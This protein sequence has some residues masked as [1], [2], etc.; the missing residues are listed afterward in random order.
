MYAFVSLLFRS[1][2]YVPGAIVLGK[3]L[4]EML[5]LKH[6][7]ILMVTHDIPE[8]AIK[9]LEKY[10]II[11][12]VEYLDFPNTLSKKIPPHRDLLDIYFSS[13]TSLHFLTISS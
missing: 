8:S 3:I 1:E 9:K 13:N 12:K 5:K 10:W 11:K 2:C 4:K 7:C 6:D